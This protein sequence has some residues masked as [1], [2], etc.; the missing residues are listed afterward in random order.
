MAAATESTR[1]GW[2]GKTAFI[3]AAIGSA[4]GLGN[5]WRFPTEAGENGG[6]A[7]VLF[8]IAAVIFI[9]LP[10][11]LAETLIGRHGQASATE[12]VRRLARES[13][14]SHHW[15]LFAV[16]GT[17]ASF[18]IVSFY[19]VLGGWVL[20]YIGVFFSE[21][22][23][24]GGGFA[25]RS[26]AE[27]A[28]IFDDLTASPGRLIA[29][30]AVFMAIT[31]FFVARGVSKGIEFVAT[32]MLP[33]FFVLFLGITVYSIFTGEIGEAAR[34]LFTFEP[35]KLTGPVMLAAV[36]QA[37]FSIGL[38]SVLM[39]TYGSYAGRDVNLGKTSGIIATADTAVALVAGLAIFPI[40]FAAGLDPAGGPGLMFVS[41]PT[42]FQAMPGGVFIGFLFF[43]MVL[44]AAL[45]SSVSLFEVPTSWA[46]ERFSLPRAPVAIVV[47]LAAFGIG[48]L[49]ALSFN[50]LSG[51][52]P[53]DGIA[54]FAGQGWFDVLDTLTGKIMLP[55]GALLTSVFVGWVA[56]NRLIDAENGI[57]GGLHL[58]WRFLVRWLC[59]LV[60]AAILVTGIVGS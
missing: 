49:A 7:F 38:G 58:F 33:A 18:L 46:A 1:D 21:L 51:V 6:G 31:T 55:V 25:G 43:V 34:Y 42:A 28:A 56:D 52:H 17:L 39:I 44:F 4:V 2:S 12:S 54:L 14:A 47:G 11:L 60:L 16:L 59:P 45:T 19:S 22:L 30:H 20:H 13:G 27:I 57:S 9:G 8:Y 24:G 48:T 29:L 23:S 5:L 26:G 3:L 37:F 41:M 36:G 15:A 53:L 40:V 32:W 50:T 10:V 35:A